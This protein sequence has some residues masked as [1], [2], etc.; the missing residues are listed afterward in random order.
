MQF[1]PSN[2]RIN[3]RLCMYDIFDGHVLSIAYDHTERLC[4]QHSGT[5]D[6]LCIL[7]LYYGTT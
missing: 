5:F 7:N 1:S 6:K 2:I 3:E 4:L